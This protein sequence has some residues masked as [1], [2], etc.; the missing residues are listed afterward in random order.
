MRCP[1]NALLSPLFFHVRHGVEP[2]IHEDESVESVFC[3]S[4]IQ[5]LQSKFCPLE[6]SL[7]FYQWTS[8]SDALIRDCCCCCRC[9][10]CCIRGG[11]DFPA[12]VEATVSRCT[13]KGLTFVSTLFESCEPY[14]R[15][16]TTGLEDSKHI[17]SKF[18]S[19]L[20]DYEP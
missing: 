9:R 3:T 18:S 17:L 13:P 7:S 1:P 4:V 15:Y 20:R 10:R 19:F 16:S 12:F 2:D 6:G 14:S 8:F 11:W 5:K